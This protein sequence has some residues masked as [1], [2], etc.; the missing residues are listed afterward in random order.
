[1]TP[2]DALEAVFGVIL[3]TTGVALLS[4]PAAFMVAGGLLMGFACWPKR[5]GT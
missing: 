2:W 5:K 3:L 4:I 1:M